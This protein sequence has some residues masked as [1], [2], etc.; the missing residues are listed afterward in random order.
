MLLRLKYTKL[1]FYL[2]F[3]VS[4]NKSWLFT[5]W[6]EHASKVYQNGKLK[7]V[8]HDKS[9]PQRIGEAHT[10]YI[11]NNRKHFGK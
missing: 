8:L 1:E 7:R 10:L 9:K 3:Y 5:H 6:E 11:Q 4:M 2:L